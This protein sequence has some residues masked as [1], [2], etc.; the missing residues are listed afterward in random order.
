MEFTAK[1]IAEL[2]GGRVEGNEQAAVSTFA[3]IEEGHEGAISFLSNPKYTHFL[4]ETK[5]TIVLVDE[6]LELEH[7]VSATL[8]R[9]KSAYEA[10]G[11]LLQLYEQMKP[12]KTGVDPLAFVSP[13][14]TIG[15]DVYIG[16][17]A[18]IGDGTVIGDGT[19][20]YPHVVVGDGVTIGEQCLLYPNVTIYQGCRLGNRVTIHAGSVIGADGFGFAP[21]QEGYDKIPQIGIVV[22]EDDVEIGANTCVDRSTMGQTVIRHGVKLDNLIQVAHNCEVGE[23]TVM[24][25]Q[26]GLAGSTKIGSWCMV[27][28]QAGFAGHIQ[29]A[30]KTFVGAQCGVI[31]NTKGQG[32]QLIGSPAMD[33]KQ[34]F[35][36]MA[37]VKRLPDIYRELNELKKRVEELSKNQ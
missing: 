22:I 9:V 20:V 5:S 12:R 31:S 24:S 27:G 8:I 2:T 11:R 14:A 30:D 29:V 19:Q 3:K 18:C 35:R 28:G 17:F 34:F 37:V 32:E 10:V 7:P 26:V 15:K 21:N 36:S 4:Y 13:K 23:N 16:A 25:A 33:P 1:Q 6:T